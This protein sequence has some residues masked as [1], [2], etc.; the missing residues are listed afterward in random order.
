MMLIV[1]VIDLPDVRQR[2]SGYSSRLRARAWL[3]AQCQAPPPPRRSPTPLPLT[4]RFDVQPPKKK[5][6]KM[7]KT[8]INI[9]MMSGWSWESPKA[10]FFEILKIDFVWNH[11]Y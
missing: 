1:G 10:I 5:E 7:K 6:K 2:S 4:N 3:A 8:F 9:E 11:H